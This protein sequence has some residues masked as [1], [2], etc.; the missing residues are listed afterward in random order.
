MLQKKEALNKYM[1]IDL[2]NI[3]FYFFSRILNCFILLYFLFN[4]YT[5]NDM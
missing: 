5:K 1:L 2:L 3:H 4:V